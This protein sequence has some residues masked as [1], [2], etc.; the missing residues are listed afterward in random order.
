MDSDTGAESDMSLSSRSFLHRVNDRVRKIQDQSSKDA[1]QDSNKHSL[2][3]W[4]FMSSTLQASVFMGKNY[5]ENLHSIKNT[6]KWFCMETFI[7]DWC[8]RSRQS[9]ARKG[10]RIFRFCVC[11]GKMSENPLSIL[12]WWTSWC[13]SKVHH[14]TEFCTQMMVS[15]GIRVEYFPGFTTLQLCYKV[16]EFMSKWTYNQKISLDGLSSCRCSTKENKQECESS[17][18]LVSIYAKRFSPGRWSFLGP[19]SEKKWYSTIGCKPQGE[20]D[21]VAELMML[22]FGESM[23]QSCRADYVKIRRK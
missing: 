12:V 5:S 6:G 13:G 17:A 11:F 1:T 2:R 19:G 21:R 3:W 16:Q 4:M 18:H 22:K 20:W 10:L 7:F 23:G 9:L 8:R 15:H 14:N